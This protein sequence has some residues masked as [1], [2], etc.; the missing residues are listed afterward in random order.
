MTEWVGTL[1]SLQCKNGHPSE[2]FPK[3]PEQHNTCV[4]LGPRSESHAQIFSSQNSCTKN[5]SSNCYR[6]K[7]KRS[8]HLWHIWT[9]R[10]SIKNEAY[11][12]FVSDI[13]VFVLKR[14]VTPTN[15]LP[16]L[17]G[18][19]TIFRLAASLQSCSHLSRRPS[20][21]P[22]C[23]N[24]IIRVSYRDVP[25]LWEG[26]SS[27]FVEYTHDMT[28]TITR[29]QR[30]ANQHFSIIDRRRRSS[31]DLLDIHFRTT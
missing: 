3:I 1:Q 19:D 30:G 13:A 4:Y 18:D 28:T 26:G 9:I 10:L 14:D 6:S 7:D 27:R 24:D 8:S 25:T 12:W 15:R 5:A 21:V 23:S 31:L 29:R 11:R 22:K 2:I 17:A 20:E 16:L